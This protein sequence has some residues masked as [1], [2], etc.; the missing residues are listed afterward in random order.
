MFFVIISRP[1]FHYFMKCFRQKSF[2]KFC[3]KSRNAADRGSKPSGRTFLVVCSRKLL[4]FSSDVVL[5]TKVLVSR[6][7]EDKK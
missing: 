7:L 6:R 1:S 4:L 5:E 2:V 3:N